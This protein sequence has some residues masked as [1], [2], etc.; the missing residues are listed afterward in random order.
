MSSSS[1]GCPSVDDGR[2]LPPQVH[3][4]ENAEIQSL[5]A[6]RRVNV[7][8]VAGEQHAA[9][10]IG[11]RLPGVV[12]E[13]RGGLHGGDR[14]VGTAHSAKTPFHLLDRDRGVAVRRGTVE[15]GHE[16]PAGDGA[17]GEHS[18]RRSPPAQGQEPLGVIELDDRLVAG[19]CGV[20][21]REFEAGE[22]R[23]RLRPP[24]HPTR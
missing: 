7:R 12:G 22:L 2:E 15:F 24:S 20:G 6:E 11:R 14:H 4:V 5:A 21:S 9:E 10:A 16:D 17:E 19:Q 1:A 13:P 18:L 8:R 3:R 23:T